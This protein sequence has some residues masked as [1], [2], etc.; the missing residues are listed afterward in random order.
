LYEQSPLLT[1]F[2]TVAV[3]LAIHAREEVPV[4]RYVS[5]KPEAELGNGRPEFD[6]TPWI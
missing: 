5:I 1:L 6:E 3:I 2:L 4:C